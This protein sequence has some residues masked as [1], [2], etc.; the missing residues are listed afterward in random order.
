MTGLLSGLSA[1]MIVHVRRAARPRWRWHATT[2]AVH[3][4]SSF[5]RN[6]DDNAIRSRASNDWPQ[7]GLGGHSTVE[8]SDAPRRTGARDD[9]LPLRELC[10]CLPGALVLGA[11]IP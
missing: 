1:L 8:R 5:A 4:F 7:A 10:N 6:G 3:S 9:R 11:A 2:P